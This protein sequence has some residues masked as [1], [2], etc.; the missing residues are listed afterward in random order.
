MD[1]KARRPDRY[2]IFSLI[3]LLVAVIL[4]AR[5]YSVAQSQG[6][7]ALEVSTSIINPLT[8]DLRELQGLLGNGTLRSVDL[9]RLYTD[10]IQ[11]HDDYLNAMIN[12]RPLQSVLKAAERLDKE[13]SEGSIRGPLHGIPIVIKDNIDTHPELGFQTTAGSYALADSWPQKNAR[14]VDLLIAAGVIIIGKANLSELS[15][16]KFV[17]PQAPRVSATDKWCRGQNITSGYSAVGGQVQSAYVRGGVDPD[18]GSN[19]HS[20]PS[21]SSAG[22][23]VAVSMGYSPFAIGTETDGSLVLPAARAALYTI[24]P[25]IGLVPQAGIVPISPNFDTAGPMAKTPYDL[26]VLL[27]AI[28]EPERKLPSY[29]SALTQSW[30]DISVA[31]LDPQVWR[32][33]DSWMRQVENA[34]QQMN[35]EIRRAYAT[36]ETLAK[37][38]AGNVPLI[39]HDAF[40]LNGQNSETVVIAADFVKAINAYLETRVNSTVR[41]LKE[42]IEFNEQHAELELSPYSPNQERLVRAYKQSITAEE[43]D[44]HFKHLRDVARN[45]G[46]DFI[47][48][49]Y[50]VDLIMAPADSLLI[51]YAACGGYPIATL[52]LS[53]LDYNG[54]PF[55]LSVIARAGQ[56]ALLIKAQSAWEAT[57]GA[58][59]PP[60]AMN[61][62][63][64]KL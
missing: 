52:P 38:Y 44:A 21:G 47:L 27:D 49:T 32:L 58:R 18:D 39:S 9:V 42:L 24:K 60:S 35:R 46:I 16:Y 53:Y 28:V 17:R 3:T 62:T 14:I 29:T 11:K 10:Q 30:G 41:N 63:S 12:F 43:Y 37:S 33:P 59:K 1:P 55:G 26:A 2:V 54:R 13:R 64:S 7:V 20:N 23:A 45:K 15:N 48:D 31:T 8:A 4:G 5:W 25:T 57:F 51:N 6:S 50:R 34:T 22:S 56:D 40:D 36:I 61:C 19:G